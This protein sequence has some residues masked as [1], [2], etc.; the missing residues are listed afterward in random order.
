MQGHDQGGDGDEGPLRPARDCAGH[1]QRC[2]DVAVVH[3]VVLGQRHRPEAALVGPGALLEGGG[4][5][6]GVGRLGERCAAQVE[7]QGGDRHAWRW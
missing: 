6:L 2:R 1:D 7:A 4:V 3:A 5:E